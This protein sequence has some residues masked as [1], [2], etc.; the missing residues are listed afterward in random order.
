[1]DIPLPNEID[2]HHPRCKVDFYKES[3]DLV[4][5]LKSLERRQYL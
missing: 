2:I 4:L 3:K 1:M 5:Q